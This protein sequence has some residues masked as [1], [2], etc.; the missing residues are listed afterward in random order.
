ME[1]RENLLGRARIL[2]EQSSHFDE[3]E[4]QFDVEATRVGLEMGNL[5]LLMEDIQSEISQLRA[6]KEFYERE[7]AIHLNEQ[8]EY[9][10]SA[11]QLHRD[12]VRLKLE[13]QEK[14]ARAERMKGEA[15]D[16]CHWGC[17]RR[18]IGHHRA[19]A[20]YLDKAASL[21]VGARELDAEAEEQMSQAN[22]NGQNSGY[23]VH[24]AMAYNTYHREL[25]DQVS[26]HVIKIGEAEQRLEEAR[27][28]WRTKRTEMQRLSDESLRYSDLAQQLTEEA[29][30]C[31]AAA[32]SV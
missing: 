22:L 15:E 25:L 13:A 7:S 17:Q 20:P 9:R 4:H 2:R 19:A 21:A 11:G 23:L 14:M 27:S 8:E 10:S 1:D 3:L 26:D 32:A 31:E 28:K 18:Q 5:E 29:E 12:G 30:R 16:Q 6:M 24:V